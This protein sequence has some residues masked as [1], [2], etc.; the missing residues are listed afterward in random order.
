MWLKGP[1]Q[2]PCQVNR[3]IW[4]M[5]VQKE[6]K[7]LSVKRERWVMLY[8][9]SLHAKAQSQSH[10]PS[11]SPVPKQWLCC[12]W[13][14]FLFHGTLIPAAWCLC[15]TVEDYFRDFFFIIMS[16]MV[17]TVR[18]RYVTGV[19]VCVHGGLSVIRWLNCGGEFAGTTQTMALNE[20]LCKESITDISKGKFTLQLQLLF[21]LFNFS[22]CW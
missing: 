2:H 8:P 18:G 14:W 15:Q 9:I 11:V 21:N 22:C 19:L 3:F 5:Q 13:M 1:D 7:E 17:R 6:G 10:N 16:G 4:I 12:K 20:H